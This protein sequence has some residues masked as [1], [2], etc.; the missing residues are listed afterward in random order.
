MSKQTTTH[1]Q[2]EFFV[3]MTVQGNVDGIFRAQTRT[4]TGAFD[5][6]TRAHIFAWMQK[7]FPPEL[8]GLPVVFFSA[9]PNRIAGEVPA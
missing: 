6:A 1:K 8:A 3:V 4:T 5:P 7:H 9:E 2:I